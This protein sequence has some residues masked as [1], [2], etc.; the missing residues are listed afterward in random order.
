LSYFW[1][2]S[3]FRTS[4]SKVIPFC[5]AVSTKTTL[6]SKLLIVPVLLN[7]HYIGLSRI[8]N[9]VRLSLQYGLGKCPRN[10][11]HMHAGNVCIFRNLLVA[12]LRRKQNCFHNA[13]RTFLIVLKVYEQCLS[14]QKLGHIR[15][16]SQTHL[17]CC[18]Q[19]ADRKKIFRDLVIEQWASL[20]SGGTQS[21]YNT[22]AVG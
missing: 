20:Y 9:S 10:L 3:S 4:E 2:L 13:A 16:G 22:L 19:S 8:Y 14:M 5:T 12:G 18:E 1:T 21:H 11:S 17:L 7:Y 6:A 15:Q